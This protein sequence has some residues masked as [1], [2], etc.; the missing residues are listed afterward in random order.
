MIVALLQMGG[1]LWLAWG[2]AWV[3]TSCIALER[4]HHEAFLTLQH[5]VPGKLSAALI[6]HKERLPEQAWAQFYSSMISMWLGVAVTI[7][8]Q[9]TLIWVRGLQRG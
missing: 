4:K 7:A 2:L 3:V 1:A 5:A 6:Y 9:L 8:F